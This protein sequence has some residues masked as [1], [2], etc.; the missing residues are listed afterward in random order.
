MTVTETLRQ[1]IVQSGQTHYRIWKETGVDTRVID[2]FVNREFCASGQTID[3]LA[4]YFGLELT[5]KKTEKT[6]KQAGK[7]G[8]TK[9]KKTD[10]TGQ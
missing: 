7:K 8:T 9:R 2:R 1:A 6:V 5:R 3:R 4:E 10:S